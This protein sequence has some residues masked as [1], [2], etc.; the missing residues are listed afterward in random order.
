MAASRVLAGKE[1]RGFY[2]GYGNERTIG[3]K[4][5][6]QLPNSCILYFYRFPSTILRQTDWNPRLICP[7]NDSSEAA[8]L[9]M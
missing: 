4:S 5:I 2:R 6:Q 1:T 9:R 7:A 8:T 3:A